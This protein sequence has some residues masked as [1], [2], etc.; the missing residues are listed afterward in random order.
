MRL[1]Q[2]A[3]LER[4]VPGT[5]PASLLR[6]GGGLVTL[7]ERRGARSALL[8]FLVPGLGQLVSR[9]PMVGAALL[10]PPAALVLLVVVAIATGILRIGFLLD[11][12]VLD[13]LLF[14]GVLLFAWRAFAVL[15]A[16]GL[17]V[18]IATRRPATVLPWLLVLLVGLTQA[19]PTLYLTDVVGTLDR[20]SDQG[21]NPDDRLLGPAPNSEP[22]IEG[23]GPADPTTPPAT[24]SP[25][26]DPTATAGPTGEATGAPSPS[27][28]PSAMPRRTMDPD[29]P[30][31]RLEE[32]VTVLLIGT[33]NLERRAHR[34]TD[35][36][37]AVSLG[38]QARR[39][40]MVSVPRDIY[41][42]PLPDGRVYNARLNSLASYARARPDEFPLGGIGTLRATIG[43][44]LGIEIDYVASIDMLGLIDVVDALGR[45]EL[46]VL[47]PIDDPFYP[48]ATGGPRG[49]H[50]DAGRQVL[51]GETALA[52]A[53]SRKGEGGNDFVRA[54]RQQRLLGAIRDRV[55]ELGLVQTFPT[56]LD[57]VDENVRT[58]VPRDRMGDFA[59]AVIDA[60]WDALDR[61]VLDPRRFV[62]PAF[63]DYGAYILRPHVGEIRAAVAAM[64][65]G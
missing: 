46:T 10:V 44:L 41:G 15:H 39:P 56:L 13:L 24:A 36:M 34:L 11:A 9:R 61:L 8:S 1:R 23:E 18:P 12:G 59:E 3:D 48:P 30:P 2:I 60:R 53:R 31:A 64:I 32:R 14:V 21:G 22:S 42:A 47:R 38:A 5:A 49:F 43:L 65:D 26:P 58:D 55:A 25:T 50:L 19:V 20:I 57:V 52:Y 29:E 54:G 27:P 7:A 17:H 4:R 62:T 37:L 40:M 16:Y 28:T 45:V 35:T 51:D 63:T 6:E 33:D